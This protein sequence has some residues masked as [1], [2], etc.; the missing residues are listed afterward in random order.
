MRRIVFDLV[1]QPLDVDG[2]RVLFDIGAGVIPERL[3]DLLACDE[4][5]RVRREEQEQP[6]LEAERTIS[7]PS[8]S[9]WARSASMRMGPSESTR[10]AAGCERR[11]V[12]AMRAKSSRGRNGLAM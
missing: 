4:L 10:F 8:R 5:A 9:T 6:V 11:I 3:A 1:A 2:E 12:A 7:S